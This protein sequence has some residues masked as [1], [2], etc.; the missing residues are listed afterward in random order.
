MAQLAS[1]PLALPAPRPQ[2]GPGPG[3]YAP[4][5]AKSG[6]DRPWPLIKIQRPSFDFGET[7]PPG[8]LAPETLAPIP[9]FLWRRCPSSPLSARGQQG[10][11]AAGTVPSSRAS[12]V[13]LSLFSLFHSSPRRAQSAAGPPQRPALASTAGGD[14]RRR[15]GSPRR[16]VRSPCAERTAVER[17]RV[18]CP[19]L[20]PWLACAP[21]TP[22]RN[23]RRRGRDR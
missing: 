16:C 21:R 3:I 18:R 8:R 22:W 20:G 9:Q 6:P 12:A 5:W 11:A 15:H 13:A 23:G 1:R 17:F 7:K 2:P 4:A 10:A 19:E 14:N